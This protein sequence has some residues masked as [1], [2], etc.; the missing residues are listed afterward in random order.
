MAGLRKRRN[1]RVKAER[2]RY[3]SVLPPPVGKKSSSTISRSARPC[4]VP[5]SARPGRFINTKASWKKR[6]FGALVLGRSP[7]CSGRTLLVNAVR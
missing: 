5:G 2:P 1:T 4:G 3:A 7:S 6:H